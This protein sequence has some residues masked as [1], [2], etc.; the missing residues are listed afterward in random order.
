MSPFNGKPCEYCRKGI[1]NPTKY[2]TVCQKCKIK[3]KKET[4][5]KMR[6]KWEKN[7]KRRLKCQK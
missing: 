4:I 5:K 6:K 2:Q 1:T 7:K 3:R